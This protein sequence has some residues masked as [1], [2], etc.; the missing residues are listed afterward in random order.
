MIATVPEKTSADQVAV[1]KALGVEIWRT[2]N[3]AHLNSAESN[4]GLAKKL[5]AEIPGSLLV[6][7]VPAFS[8]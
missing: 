8:C 3:K 4:I 7:E 5:A 1:L 6:D 2:P